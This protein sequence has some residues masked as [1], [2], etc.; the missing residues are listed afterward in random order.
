[1]SVDLHLHT[2]ASD[3]IYTPSQI[4][5]FACQNSLSAISITDHD[6]VSGIDEAISESKKRLEV[7][8]GLEISCIYNNKDIH[9][10]GYFIDHNSE[11]LRKKLSEFNFTRHDRAKKMASL[12]MEQG[13]DL[14]F[15]EILRESGPAAPGRAHVARLMVKK[16]YLPNTNTA[17]EKYLKRGRCCYVPKEGASADESISLIHDA[18]GISSLAH[19][20]P[21]ELDSSEI[22]DLKSLGIKAIEVFHPDHSNQYSEELLNLAKELGLLATGGSDSHGPYR[23]KRPI[24]FLE[25][26]NEYFLALKASSD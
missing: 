7:V 23:N 22:A 15:D 2:T 18:G 6:T 20:G 1:M 3:G 8:P 26:K 13:F 11:I 4:V 5:N 21:S 19:P 17:F 12:I 16:G 14:S 24:E 9:I 10:L 25:V